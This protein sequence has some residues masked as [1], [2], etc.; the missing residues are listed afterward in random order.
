MQLLHMGLAHRRRGINV[1]FPIDRSVN[2]VFGD[3]QGV[4]AAGDEAKLVM[5]P[6]CDF[7]DEVGS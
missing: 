6:Y 3:S 5:T 2:A 7:R 4:S 1:R